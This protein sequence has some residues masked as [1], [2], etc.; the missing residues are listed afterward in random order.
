MAYPGHFRRA[1]PTGLFLLFTPCLVIILLGQHVAGHPSTEALDT[2]VQPKN[3]FDGIAP[4]SLPDFQVPI[5]K[6][7]PFVLVS[8]ADIRDVIARS[9]SEPRSSIG[10]RLLAN[11]QEY[12]G[13]EAATID[14]IRFRN[15]YQV[16]R[17]FLLEMVLASKLTG[18][19]EYREHAFQALLAREADT[20][21]N[22]DFFG[23]EPHYVGTFL[24]GLVLAYDIA[25]Q[26]LPSAQRESTA[27]IIRRLGRFLYERSLT[28]GWGQATPQRFAWN[29]SM[30][31]YGAMG[32]AAVGLG[33]PD[34]ETANWLRRASIATYWHLHRDGVTALGANPEGLTYA[35]YT[36]RVVAPFLETL[37]LHWGV[38]WIASERVLRYLEW[39]LFEMIPKGSRTHNHNDAL[40]DPHLALCGYL[41]MNRVHQS[42]LARLV[43]D[44][45]V[46]KDG[47]RTYGWSFFDR[48]LLHSSL[49]EAF[50]FYPDQGPLI[51]RSQVD[52]EPF[53]H[54]GEVGLVISKTDWS[55]SAAM[56][57]FTSSQYLG[58]IHSQSD[59]NSFTLYYQGSPMIVDSGMANKRRE[60]SASQTVG[61]NSIL[62]DGRGMFLSGEGTGTHGRILFVE[63]QR[64]VDCFVG[65]ARAAYSYRGFN[66]VSRAFRHVCFVKD[67]FPYL[68][69]WDDIA[70]PGTE[71]HE[72]EFLLHLDRRMTFVDRTA[73]NT[74][75]FSDLTS[76]ESLAVA[77]LHPNA[78]IQRTE[79][80]YVN[81][82]TEAPSRH[83]R[84]QRFSTVAVNPH[85]VTLLLP[86]P[87]QNPIYDIQEVSI[88]KKHSFIRI[89]WP[90]WGF[91]DRFEFR[92][93]VLPLQPDHEPTPTWRRRPIPVDQLTDA[94]GPSASVAALEGRILYEPQIIHNDGQL[95]DT[96]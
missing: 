28:A 34:E 5:L 38:D 85:F 81:P 79:E 87:M 66:R 50:L 10:L 30:I 49:V 80:I 60:G 18:N 89:R 94:T 78:D 83:H 77:F 6:E 8:E 27:T 84:L 25:Y 82:Y 40:T 20:G 65:D 56:F 55:R 2:A 19:P 13:Y 59:K 73:Q 9:H 54:F 68:V 51:A 70:K 71:A 76:H 32:L 29:H 43:W 52:L 26:D 11:A 7:H 35:G 63:H 62:I 58:A 88:D 4:S 1:R 72:F 3:K 33:N 22:P 44:N 39:F 17:N 74:F 92:P 48:D 93:V 15:R 96:E 91:E 86:G 36:N 42:P 31:G 69:V 16:W 37:R 95:S 61:H 45:L 24:A 14:A 21:W 75:R 41:T 12:L 53:R 47:D 90:E 67:P 23:D 57:T 64:T 46:G